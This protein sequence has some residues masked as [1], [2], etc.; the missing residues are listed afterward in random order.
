MF[1]IN[2]IK[3]GVIFCFYFRV[4]YGFRMVYVGRWWLIE[5]VNVLEVGLGIDV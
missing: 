5:F 1:I 2:N 4:Y 3:G